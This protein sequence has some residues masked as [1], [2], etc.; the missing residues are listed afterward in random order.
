M[1]NVSKRDQLRSSQDFNRNVNPAKKF[2]KWESESKAFSYYDPETKLKVLY[3]LPFKFVTLGRPLFCIKGFNEKLN[4]GI[5]SNEVRSVHDEIVVRYFDKNQPLI[6]KGVW[7]EVKGIADNVGGKY[8][9]SIY[10]YDLEIKE[11][12]NID[13]KGMGIGEWGDLFKKN[14]TRI[15]D[16]IIIVNKFKEGKKG[17]VKYTYPTFELERSV[18]DDELDDVINALDEL[19]K[20]H[21][22]YFLKNKKTEIKEDDIILDTGEDLDF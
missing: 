13:V 10:A 22:E 9:L 6:A 4:L 2:F 17:S 5:Y 20:Y 18:S 1:N 11:I 16:E 14:S 12:I 19:K 7:A 21:F 3:Q 8:H 15:A